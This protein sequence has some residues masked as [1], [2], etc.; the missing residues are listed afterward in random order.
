MVDFAEFLPCIA[1]EFTGLGKCCG[2]RKIYLLPDRA[3][4][5]YIYLALHEIKLPPAIR[6]PLAS[7]PAGIIISLLTK[8]AHT[9]SLI[10]NLTKEVCKKVHFHLPPSCFGVAFGPV[11]NS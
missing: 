11:Y 4:V 8:F 10:S 1:K 9:C 5:T 6:Q 7:S 2:S 3:N